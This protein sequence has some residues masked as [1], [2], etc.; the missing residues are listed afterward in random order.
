M[1]GAR[2]TAETQV[3]AA[4]VERGEGAELLG[5]DERAVVG[6]HDAAGADANCRCRRGDVADE[7]GRRRAGD[8]VHVVVLGE[9]DALEGACLLG[10]ARQRRA[11]GERLTHGL[12][13]G[14][15]G[16]VEDGEAGVGHVV[17][18]MPGSVRGV[19]P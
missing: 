15:E 7:D 14:D 12:A 6:E 17:D 5:N 11:V 18:G 4:G 2:G 1:V 10:L 13:L 9:P 3:D 8:R 16:E 19:M